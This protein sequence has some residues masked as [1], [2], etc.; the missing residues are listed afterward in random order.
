M[1]SD[2]ER[3]AM[4]HALGLAVS[5]DAPRGPNPRVGCIL[6]SPDGAEV[7][8]GHHRGAGTPHAE[9]NAIRDAGVRARG[10]TA[11]VTLEPCNHTGRTGPCTAALIDAG[12]RRVVYA[13]SDDSAAAS[14]GAHRLRAI[15]IDVEGGLLDRE[16][17]AVNPEWS[18]AGSMGRP[19]V[20]YKMATSLDGR[21]SAADGTSQWITGTIARADVHARRAEVDA[22]VVGTGTVLADDPRL[23]VRDAEDMPLPADRQ[24]RRV[25]VGRRPLPPT[26]RVLQGDRAATVVRSHDPHAVLA[27]LTSG[28]ARH[29]WLE[30]GPRLGGAFLAAG[31]VDRVVVYQAGLLLG[32]GLPAVVGAGV[33]T[34]ADAP[35]WRIDDV[36]M[37]GADV[38]IRAH[39]SDLVWAGEQPHGGAAGEESLITRLTTTIPE[40]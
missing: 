8:R 34:L 25:V 36:T 21:V 17:R 38:R 10:A 31:L 19:F 12:V 39:R 24:P 37:V 3:A 11:V 26:A 15:G 1:A 6:L 16:A 20:T 4:R 14:G 9:V 29:V 18:L 22:V 23:T 35:R 7:G 30:G 27:E 33:G 28:G 32:D 2:A 5:A 40:E 13:Q